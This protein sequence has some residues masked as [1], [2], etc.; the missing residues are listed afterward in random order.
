MHQSI[1]NRRAVIVAGRR[2]PFVKAGTQLA[3]LSAVDLAALNLRQ[4]VAAADLPL[5][6]LDEVLCGC[7]LPPTAAPNVAREAILRNGLP[8]RI[9][10]LTMNR[11]CTSSLQTAVSA[12]EMI[13]AGSANAVVAMGVESLSQMPIPYSRSLLDGLQALK[14]ADGI[15]A[16][17]AALAAI[18]L[19]ELLPGMPAI[20]ET[21]TGQS[22]GQHADRMA[23]RFGA[24]RQA[25]D[26]WAL[27][28]HQR[29]AAA[30]TEGRF[31]GEIH[32]VWPESGDPAGVTLDTGVRPTTSLAAL[33]ALKP[34]FD[35]AYGTVTAGN[36]SPMTDGA[37]GLLVME[38]SFA[39]ANG[40]V[41]LAAIK[42]WSTVALDPAD[43]LLIGPALAIPAAL[44]KAG[45]AWSDIGLTELHEAFAAQVV[46]TFAALESAA[47]AKEY[48]GA[49]QAVGTVDRDRVNVD[50][51][52]L[53]IGHPF[54]ATGARLL[55][56]ATQALHRRDETFAMVAACAAGGQGMAIVLER[57]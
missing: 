49:E 26:E 29:A 14:R 20:A 54:G 15:P 56:H 30:Q 11:A 52:S 2:T 53:A 21:S 9:P 8:R 50:G 41:P 57:L 43:E 44:R 7:V 34:V 39:R 40:Y 3:S 6:L 18:P 13:L 23:Q 37:A 19:G 17:M 36:A 48:L 38:E 32:P 45:L 10:G 16:K 35:K 28:S 47:F 46:S 12:A 42:S 5:H 1:G 31:A 55:W 24:T 4:L 25:Q 27:I 51:G 33:G 22:M